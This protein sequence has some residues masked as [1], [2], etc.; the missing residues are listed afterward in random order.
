MDLFKNP[1]HILGAT[2]RDN[3]HRIIELAEERSLL[4]DADACMEARAILINPRRRISAEVAWLPGIDPSFYGLLFRYL[5]S[6]NEELPSITMAPIASANLRATKLARHP[7]LS[8]SDIVEWVLT[9]AQVSESI[10]SET[11]CAILNADRSVSGFPEITDLSTLD[12]AIRN[13]KRCYSQIATSVLENL[14]VNARARVMTSLLE[15]TT[16]NGRYQCPTLIR[17]LIPAYEGSVQDSLEQLERTIEAQDERLRS[18]ADTNRPDTMLSPI[19]DQ[20]LESLREW[21]ALVQPIQLSRQSTGQRHDASSEMA[22]RFRQLAADLFR[23]YRQPDFSRRI[24]NTLRSVFSEVPEIVEQ[25]NEDLNALEEQARLVETMEEF[26]NINAQVE[27]LREA[28]DARQS[29][30]ILLP[31]VNQ[32][33]QSVRSWDTT[34]PVDANSVVVF[35]VREVALHL[36]NQHQKLDFAIQITNA[37]I[38]VFNTNSVG[39]EVVTRLIEDRTTLVGMRSFEKIKTQVEKL[40]AAA[41]ARHPDYTLTPMVNQLIQSVRSWDTTQPVDAN[42]V[43]AFTVREVALHLCNQHQKLDF[44]IQITNALIGIFRGVYGMDEVNNRL[45]EDISTLTN[46]SE[47]RRRQK[48]D[49]PE[50]RG[51]SGCLTD[52]IIGYAVVFGIGGILALI[53]SLMESC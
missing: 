28:S 32:L 19:V 3:R 18:M 21:D 53:G 11:V 36:C 40:K 5:E 45:S 16:S 20:L 44:A 29:D 27:Q 51:P 43:V 22:R 39:A 34:Q 9:I 38:E 23:E 7:G 25:I 15:T 12:D 37:L 2:T 6:P 4:S 10:N 42:S 48:Q 13:H 31:L 52:R 26:G 8:S 30:D 50:D 41:D 17:D 46:M 49:R 1:F 33:I 14:A 24:L 47:Q 35:T